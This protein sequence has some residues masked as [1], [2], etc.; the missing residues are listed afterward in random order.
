MIQITN[1]QL[2]IR[3]FIEVRPPP[4]QNYKRK[5]SRIEQKENLPCCQGDPN[6]QSIQGDPMTLQA[7]QK[8]Q[9]ETLQSELFIII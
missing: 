8:A 7:P 9:T 5:E 6:E 3:D 1:I 4:K 2:Q